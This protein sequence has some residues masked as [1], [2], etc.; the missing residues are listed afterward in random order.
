MPAERKRPGV[1][2]VEPQTPYAVRRRLKNGSVNDG[3]W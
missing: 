1:G 3:G 2:A